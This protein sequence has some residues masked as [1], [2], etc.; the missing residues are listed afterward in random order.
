LIF[1]LVSSLVL[2]FLFIFILELLSTRH[3]QDISLVSSYSNKDRENIRTRGRHKVGRTW[4]LPKVL[5]LSSLFI[6]FSI[7]LLFLLSSVSRNLKKELIL[8]TSCLSLMLF[9]GDWLKGYNK[10][11]LYL[12]LYPYDLSLDQF[13]YAMSPGI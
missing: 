12:S 4:H 10:K 3:S 2:P 7:N 5:S 9:I 1:P 11:G 6:S 8:Y 13:D